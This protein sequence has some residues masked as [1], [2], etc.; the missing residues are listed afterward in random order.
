VTETALATAL[1][2]SYMADQLGN[3]GLVVGV[4]LL[5]AGIG[6]TSRRWRHDRRAR[7]SQGRPDLL[8]GADYGTITGWFRSEIAAVYGPLV[9]AALA[10]TGSAAVTAGEEEDRITALVL[11]HPIRRSRLVLAKAAAIAL[12]VPIVAFATWVGMMLGV[13]LGAAASAS[14]TS[15]P[16]RSN[17][18][19]SGSRPAGSPSA[20]APAGARSPSEPLPGSRSPAG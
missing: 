14:G 12:V 11:A 18:R 7:P 2:T 19:S 20:P 5:L 16:S 10:I 3:F 15:P 8:G 9:I 4:A 17:W 6:F 13:A 1:N